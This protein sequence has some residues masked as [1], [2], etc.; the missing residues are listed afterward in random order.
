MAYGSFES[1]FIF[2]LHHKKHYNY[3]N[4]RYNT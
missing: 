3:D 1:R 4:P 2:I